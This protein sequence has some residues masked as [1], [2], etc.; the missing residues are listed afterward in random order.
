MARIGQHGTSA[1]G[2]VVMFLRTAMVSLLLLALSSC[3]TMAVWGFDTESRRDP[4]TGASEA[5]YTYDEETQWSW[6]L[7][8]GRVLVT[9]VTLL[10][11]CL[12]APAQI[13]LFGDGDDEHP[14]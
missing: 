3:F 2:L 10:L 6:E 7:F 8:L 4:F 14:K 5:T 1:H 12:T 11:D 9:P 13:W